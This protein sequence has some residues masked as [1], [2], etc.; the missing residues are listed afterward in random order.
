M[1]K[2]VLL[3]LLV[4][5]SIILA[6]CSSGGNDGKVT[7]VWWSHDNP[8][9]V[10]ANK[11]L[12]ADYETMN[13]DVKIHLHIFPYDAMVQQLKAAYA[14]KHPP[15]MAKTCGSWVHPYARNVLLAEVPLATCDWVKVSV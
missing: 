3:I 5:F 15:D 14:G 11:K 1:R 7:L 9:F 2:K 12:I 8:T 6:S 13:P 10:N 4:S